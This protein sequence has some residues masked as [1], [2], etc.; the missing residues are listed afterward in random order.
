MNAAAPTTVFLDRDGVI[1]RNRV[2]YVLQ[3]DQLELLPGAADAIRR[4]CAAGKRVMVVT[5]QSVVGRGLVSSATLAAIHRRLEDMVAN[6][7]GGIERIFVCPHHPSAGC[8]C[9]KPRPGL[10]FAARLEAGIALEESVLVGDMPSDVEAARAAGCGAVLIGA[11]GSVDAP[12]VPDLS[13]AVDLL[14]GD[15][16][17]C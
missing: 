16:V 5:N 4:L 3:P 12:T 14:L 10:L 7:Y 9:R 6:E 2:G 1:V 8:N 13:A 11:G 17:A 15:R